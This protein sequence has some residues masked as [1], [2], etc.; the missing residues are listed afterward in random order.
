MLPAAIDKKTTVELAVRPNETKCRITAKNL[1]ESYEFDI[2]TI[3]PVASGWPNYILGVIHELQQLGAKIGAFECKIE[4][5]VPVG[6]GMSSSA[7]LECCIAYALNE[8]FSLGLDKF[9]MIKAGQMAEHNF[10]GTKCGIMDQFASMMGRENHL[11]LLDC[12]SLA[13]QY[14]P[15]ELGDYEVLLL[16]SKVSHSHATSAYNDRRAD[17]ESAVAVLQQR[18]PET[19]ALRDVTMEM[20][21]QVKPDL[22]GK[23]F[24]RARHVISENARVLTAIEALK[25]GDIQTVGKLMYQSHHSLQYDYEVSCKELDYLVG[26]TQDKSYIL[27]SRMMGGGFGGCSINFIHRAHA[28]NFIDEAARSYRDTFGIDLEPYIVSIEDGTKRVG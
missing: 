19:K 13:F 1:N 26:L 25:V 7:A 20:L 18:Y 17:S 16:N 21:L 10:V 6:S 12:R 2:Q 24:V 14:I 15:F 22:P 3:K 8:A 9:A 27:G 28:Q 23:S 5:N 11:I 4:G